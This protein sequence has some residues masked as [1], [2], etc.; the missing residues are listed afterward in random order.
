MLTS[1]CGCSRRVRPRSRTT[2]AERSS[3]S[4]T[5][6]SCLRATAT[7]AAP[8]GW[9]P[10]T[11]WAITATPR[12]LTMMTSSK[13]ASRA[14]CR[15]RS[16]GEEESNSNCNLLSTFHLC[17]YITSLVITT[18]ELTYS[19]I[20]SDAKL[21]K[22][23][24]DDGSININTYNEPGSKAQFQKEVRDRIL[25]GESVENK[26]FPKGIYR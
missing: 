21:L 18:G 3:S 16:G 8:R 12:P 13:L 4:L 26:V 22:L 7:T 6:A 15:Q 10:D 23:Q 20:V 14:C 11:R 19:N 17:V 25:T 1:C 9:A 2:S 24:Q 5:R